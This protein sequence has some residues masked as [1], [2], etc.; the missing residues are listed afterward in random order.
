[1][2]ETRVPAG[3]TLID[4][5]LE[6]ER[7]AG[8]VG[9]TPELTS[10]IQHWGDVYGLEEREQLLLA[11]ELAFFTDNPPDDSIRKNYWEAYDVAAEKIILGLADR[12]DGDRWK[13]RWGATAD[14]INRA[15]RIQPGNF[16]FENV[17]GGA[18]RHL[19]YVL[20]NL[21]HEEILDQ[22]GFCVRQIGRQ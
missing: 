17:E 19:R 8:L 3:D 1:M 16:S 11:N 2:G 15:M 7:I 9:V 6:V 4:F 14:S 22:Y 5:G 13:M 10:E 21:R 12:L 18:S 20:F